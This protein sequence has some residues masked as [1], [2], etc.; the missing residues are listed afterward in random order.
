M[1]FLMKSIL[2]LLLL[3]WAVGGI[4]VLDLTIKSLKIESQSDTY[5]LLLSITPI[6]IFITLTFIVFIEGKD[7]VLEEIFHDDND[8]LTERNF[9]LY[10]ESIKDILKILWVSFR[11]SLIIA[12]IIYGF[13]SFVMPTANSAIMKEII[14]KSIFSY[15]FIF[16]S[17]LLFFYYKSLKEYK[18]TIFIPSKELNFSVPK[19]TLYNK[20]RYSNIEVSYEGIPILEKKA[21]RMVLIRLNEDILDRLNYLNKQKL[22]QLMIVEDSNS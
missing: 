8:F 15:I 3:L 5:N 16:C 1:K 13:I 11:N 17:T 10:P 7:L 6:F 19:V 18:F 4:I 2:N 14:H 22:I 21:N 20:S 12:L 9:I